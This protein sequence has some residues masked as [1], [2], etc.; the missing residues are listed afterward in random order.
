MKKLALV[1]SILALSTAASA[2]SDPRADA[3]FKKAADARAQAHKDRDEAGRLA[4]QVAVLEAKAIGLDAEALRDDAMA[5]G[6]LKADAKRLQAHK[7]RHQAQEL[8]NKAHHAQNTANRYHA[9]ANQDLSDAAKD[10]KAAADL[11]KDQ[12][13]LIK[14]VKDAAASKRKEAGVLIGLAKGFEAA[15]A[16]DIAE[17]GKLYA[18]A[19]KLDP[20]IIMQ[21]RPLVKTGK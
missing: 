16:K 2:V 14:E 3:L 17:A 4:L 15:A 1:L 18:E 7:L 13:K 9:R 21:I 5:L 6:I 11:P 20:I 10:E 19:N 8:M 12:P